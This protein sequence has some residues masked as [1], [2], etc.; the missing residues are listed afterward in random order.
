VSACPV[1]GFRVRITLEGASGGA[2][3]SA[4]RAAL[5][6][7]LAAQ[8]LVSSGALGPTGGELTLRG[9]GAQATHADRDFVATWLGRRADVARA[10]VGDL[11]DLSA[12][13]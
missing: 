1:F 10:L 3:P 12:E 2:D 9:E 7:A 4:L 5:D 11:L 6:A 8:G 13:A